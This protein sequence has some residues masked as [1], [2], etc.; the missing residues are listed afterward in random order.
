MDSITY[1]FGPLVVPAANFAGPLDG[2]IDVNIRTACRGYSHRGPSHGHGDIY[3]LLGIG[4]FRDR[5]GTGGARDSSPVLH[6]HP[7]PVRLGIARLGQCTVTSQG[8]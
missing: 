3:R 2:P 5:A 7:Q 4:H 6:L 8:A 1:N